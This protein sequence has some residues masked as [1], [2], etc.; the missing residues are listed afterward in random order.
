MVLIINNVLIGFIVVC[1][2]LILFI[3][4]L[5]IC[6]WFVVFINSILK[7]CLCVVL[8]VLLIIL[9]GFCK[10]VD[11]KKLMLIFFVRVLS[12]LIVVG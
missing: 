1:N 12:C 3:M 9:I 5:L 2:V 8:M 11:G 6:R 4:L 10:M 7:N